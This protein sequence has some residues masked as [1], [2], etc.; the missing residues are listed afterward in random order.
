MSDIDDGLVAALSQWVEKAEDDSRVMAMLLRMEKCPTDLVGFHAQQC[1]EKYM[2]AVLVMNRI[3][4]PK[5]HDLN[6]IFRLMPE[7]TRP[8]MDELVRRRFTDYATVLRYPG[9]G[10]PIP[11]AEAR[12]AVRIARRV[13][14]EIRQLLPKQARRRR[15]QA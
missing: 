2:K 8:E 11:M 7:S 6:A 9:G 1:I 14:K 15:R 3:G 12:D 5:T 13:R 10:A 4:F